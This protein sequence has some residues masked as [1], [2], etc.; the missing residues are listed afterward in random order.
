MSTST[1]LTPTAI[2]IEPKSKNR[3]L[4]ILEPLRKGFGHTLGN[5]LRRTLLSSIQGCAVVEAKIEGALHEYATL[6]GVQEDVLT[7]LLN[8]SE[9]AF[10]LKGNRDEVILVLKSNQIGPVTLGTIPLPHDVEIANP[11]HVI[12]HLTQQR[13]LNITLKVIRGQGERIAGRQPLEGAQ[14]E[15]T[16]DTDVNTLYLNA[17]FNPIKRV[18]YW[19]ENARVG[20]RT[21]LDKLLIDLETNG[22]KTP[23]SAVREA[24]AIF[25]K[26]A[27]QIILDI[28]VPDE[29]SAIVKDAAMEP[30]LLTSIDQLVPKLSARSLHCLKAE[31]VYFVGDLITKTRDALLLTPALGKRSL[32]EIETVLEGHSLSLGTVLP[33]WPPAS[34]N[35]PPEEEAKEE[36]IA[37]G[38]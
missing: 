14:E 9:G 3:A 4:V 32:K 12:A 21:D 28:K 36:A 20:E 23:E 24:A 37:K 34:L 15:E 31:G 33:D 30:I 1:F 6:E 38:E 13:E 29:K 25:F 2:T 17:T 7:I 18:T 22:T 10:T 5:V 27:L 8:L 16:V 19:V 35:Y 11:D 26:E